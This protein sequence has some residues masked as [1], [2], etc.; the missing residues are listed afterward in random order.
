MSQDNDLTSAVHAAVRHLERL[1]GFANLS[2]RRVERVRQ[3]ARQATFSRGCCC[4][5]DLVPLDVR[6]HAALVPLED[7]ARGSGRPYQACSFYYASWRVPSA[8]FPRLEVVEL[9]WLREDGFEP[10]E[11]LEWDREFQGAFCPT[12]FNPPARASG[13]AFSDADLWS[14]RRKVI[15]DVHEASGRFGHVHLSFLACDSQGARGARAEYLTACSR[16]IPTAPFELNTL[17]VLPVRVGN[18]VRTFS[19]PCFAVSREEIAA[20]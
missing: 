16:S 13:S 2:T 1:V 18:D 15:K 20:L 3:E 12:V 6:F 7:H 17:R 8:S 4:D 14:L 19:L 9:P 10:R 11:L 5:G